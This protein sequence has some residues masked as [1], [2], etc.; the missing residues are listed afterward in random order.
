ML[1]EGKRKT[2]EGQEAKT[3]NERTRKTVEVAV[4]DK[5]DS[6]PSEEGR[7]SRKREKPVEDGSSDVGDLERKGEGSAT[8]STVSVIWVSSNLTTHVGVSD[9]AEDEDS[10]DRPKRSSGSVDVGEELGSVSGLGEGSKGPGSGVNARETDGE[11][12]DANCSVD[13]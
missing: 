3:T 13:K 6:H 8:A 2:E 7:K 4:L 11:D 9:E 1:F 5:E 10:A 12:G